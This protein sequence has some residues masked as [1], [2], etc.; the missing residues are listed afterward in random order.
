MRF[1]RDAYLHLTTVPAVPKKEQFALIF[2]RSSLVDDDFKTER[3]PPG[4][5]GASALYNEFIKLIE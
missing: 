2:K 4:S 5:S 3:S 1:L